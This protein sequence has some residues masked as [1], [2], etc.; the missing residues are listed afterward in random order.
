MAFNISKSMLENY[1][2]EYTI[3]DINNQTRKFQVNL[4]SSWNKYNNILPPSTPFNPNNYDYPIT[5]RGE[6][7]NVGGGSY[8]TSYPVYNHGFGSYVLTPSNDFVARVDM[9]AGGGGGYHNSGG[10]NGGGGGYTQAIV[11]FKKNIPYTIVVGEGGGHNN[12]ATHGGGGRGHSSGGSGGGLS[13]IF[14]NSD[15]TG[16]ASW[17]HNTPPLS[18][19]NALV[20]AG[21]G[22]GKGH[23]STGN[24]G[25]AGGGGGWHGKRAHNSG[26]GSQTGGGSAGYGNSSA[27]SELHGGH[28]AS[29]TSW[30]GGG[31]GGW[32]GGGGGGHTS[33]HY[34]GGGGGSGHIAYDTTIGSQP[35]NNLSQFI[36]NGW[37]E[38]APGH[39][40]YTDWRPAAFQHPLNVTEGRHAGQGGYG[41]NNSGH[42]ET[43]GSRHGKVVLTLY[44]EFFSKLDYPKHTDPHNSNGW[45]Q[46]F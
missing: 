29:N 14:M 12:A 25:Q 45:S 28:S 19:A 9:W 26:G 4:N 35:N 33:S 17:S 37:M 8:L 10:A 38:K 32:Y 42:G 24:H 16:T 7:F 40:E 18:R 23:H 36:I 21:G 6:L 41:E 34:N 31:G 11:K 2:V 44:P 1:G 46:T 3:K 22:G 39:H 27:G 13:G 15:H 5:R 30:M 43:W 20:I